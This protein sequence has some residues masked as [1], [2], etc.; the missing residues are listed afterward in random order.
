MIDQLR[1]TATIVYRSD[2]SSYYLDENRNPVY[3]ETEVP[4]LCSIQ[5]Y[6]D[7]NNTFRVPE[8]FNSIYG[9]VVFTET[10]IITKDELNDTVADEIEFEGHRFVC[11]DYAPW[12]GYGLST[13]PDFYKCL[14]YRRD[15]L[16]TI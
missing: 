13:I 5:P 10:K 9:I 16:G 8:G 12:V 2:T 14:F 1:K 4:I 15:K 11:V 7:G 6:Q 3:A